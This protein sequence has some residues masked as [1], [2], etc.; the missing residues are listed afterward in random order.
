MTPWRKSWVPSQDPT[1]SKYLLRVANWVKEQRQGILEPTKRV[2]SSPLHYV[3]SSASGESR[4]VPRR[5]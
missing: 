2:T 1:Q 5:L 3:L 4:T